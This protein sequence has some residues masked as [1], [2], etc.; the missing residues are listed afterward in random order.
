MQTMKTLEDFQIASGYALLI[1][2]KVELPYDVISIRGLTMHTIKLQMLTS[3]ILCKT[4]Q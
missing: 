1:A 4:V 3:I 2:K